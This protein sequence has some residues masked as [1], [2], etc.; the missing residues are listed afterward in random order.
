MNRK[1]RALSLGLAAAQ[2]AAFAPAYSQ[3]AF[4]EAA[5]P[6]AK[7]TTATVTGVTV[8]DYADDGTND[9]PVN[10][11][12]PYVKVASD[13]GGWNVSVNVGKLTN[14]P[15]DNGV[16]AGKKTFGLKVALNSAD[17]NAATKTTFDSFAKDDVSYVMC[18]SKETAM[19]A[20]YPIPDTGND[21][22]NVAGGDVVYDNDNKPVAMQVWLCGEDFGTEDETDVTVHL[23]K[24]KGGENGLTDCTTEKA[25]EITLHLKKATATEITGVALAQTSS[26]EAWAEN[27]KYV[28][29]DDSAAAGDKK[30]T[31]KA[32]FGQM[33]K[34][35][36]DKTHGGAANPIC[37][38]PLVVTFDAPIT[39]DA[40]GT[41]YGGYTLWEGDTGKIDWCSNSSEN[42]AIIWLDEDCVGDV[43]FTLGETNYTFTVEDVSKTVLTPAV[44][45]TIAFED[46]LDAA[47][48]GDAI[49]PKLLENG[50]L[51]FSDGTNTAELTYSDDPATTDFD[52]AI[53]TAPSDGTTANNCTATITLKNDAAE[54]YAFADA[55]GNPVDNTTVTF[56]VTYTLKAEVVVNVTNSVTEKNSTVTNGTLTLEKVTTDAEGV[57]TTTAFTTGSKLKE[58]DT[59]RLTYKVTGANKFDDTTSGAPKVTLG[60][61]EQTAKS[62]AGNI[63]VYEFTIGT[64]SPT[65]I[66]VAGNIVEDKTPYKITLPTA[67]DGYTVNATYN[68]GSSDVAIPAEGLTA[69]T[70]IK[71]TVTGEATHLLK[72]AKLEGD[73]SATTSTGGAAIS[74]T[75]TVAKPADGD[76]I[77][78]SNALTVVAAKKLTPEVSSTITPAQLTKTKTEC[79]GSIQTEDETVVK[80]AA[81]AALGTSISD[82]QPTDYKLTIGSITDN[83]AS[84]TADTVKVTLALTTEAQDKFVFTTSSPDANSFD[85]NVPLE[86]VAEYTVGTNAVANA[87]IAVT[88]PDGTALSGGVK[89]GTKV[90]ITV[91]GDTNYAI[92]TEPSVTGVTGVTFT[93]NETTKGLWEGSYTVTADDAAT[94]TTTITATVTATPVPVVT[95]AATSVT[96]TLANTTKLSEELDADDVTTIKNAV[97]S[98]LTFK[99]EATNAALTEGTDINENTDYT[100]GEPTFT[101]GNTTVTVKVSPVDSSNFALTETTINVTVTYVKAKLTAPTVKESNASAA[102]SI[103]KDADAATIQDL[104]VAQLDLP[105][106]FDES[107][108]DIAVANATVTTETTTPAD[109]TVTYTIKTANQNDYEFNTGAGVTAT[110]ATLQVKYI[111]TAAAKEITPVITV[112]ASGKVV[113]TEAPTAANVATEINA[114]VAITV[115]GGGDAPTTEHYT[116]ETTYDDNG[117]ATVTFALTDKGK[118]GYKIAGGATTT[119]TVSVYQ[120]LAL[121]TVSKVTCDL[122]ASANTDAENAIKQAVTDALTTAWGEDVM[123]HVTVDTPTGVNAS[124]A[125][126]DQTVAVPVTLSG[127]YVLDDNATANATQNVN[128]TY[129]VVEPLPSSAVTKTPATNGSFVVK[130]D[131]AEVTGNVQQGETV[132]VVPTAAEGYEIDKVTYAVGAA[133]A[134]EITAAADGSYTFEM[135]GEA[136]TVTVTFKA[137]ET[138]SVTEHNVTIGSMTNGRVTA[139][140]AKA[141]ENA[142][143]T[144]TVTPGAG[145]KLDTLTIAKASTGTVAPTKVNDTTYK[146]TMPAEAVTVSATFVKDTAAPTKPQSAPAAPTMRRRANTSI[147]LNAISANA[148]GAA[149]EYSKDGKTWQSSPTFTGLTRNTAYT[150]YARYAAVEGF[151]ASPASAGTEIKTTNTSSSGGSSGGGS[152]SGGSSWH[153]S[154]GG[155]STSSGSSPADSSSTT[156]PNITNDT[157]DDIDDVI[158]TKPTAANISKITDK[159][160]DVEKALKNISKP[161]VV[162]KQAATVLDAAIDAAKKASTTAAK[163]EAANNIQL[164]M[165]ALNTKAPK[166]RGDADNSG[167]VDSQDVLTSV[168]NFRK[169]RTNAAGQLYSA[170]IMG[171]TDKTSINTNDILAFIKAFRTR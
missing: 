156:T 164:I 143:V 19:G 158:D 13:S 89:A 55:S 17:L 132:T 125:A 10:K 44:S 48:D 99:N 57:E 35:Q 157:A 165:K 113:L 52:V 65:S 124:A 163:E 34:A 78:L 83:S 53:K 56:S 75:Y 40:N 18:Y 6:E 39:A 120:K 104:L 154:S 142:E 150:F 46:K 126:T 1:K 93:E 72:S 64:T 160:E 30:W 103:P 90:K 45:G 37:S 8:I 92:K 118:V 81:V 138:P 25:G 67:G 107:L 152:S 171:V 32:D 111:V 80:E 153:P 123:A 94:G 169:Y 130:V 9:G 133:A 119:A 28:T 29:L 145:Y 159:A 162:E 105:A 109:A 168:L 108:F 96:A 91:K 21:Y 121:P 144:L 161:S 2:L 116:L 127:I 82:L 102:A 27:L 24:L 166:V 5:K 100:I 77:D 139:N 41:L 136:V 3:V 70:E 51:T 112:P 31:L 88:K 36:Q 14:N 148:N 95:A 167:R 7:A 58:G 38:F 151:A 117:T 26:T 60:T 87:V 140:K 84:S 71:I 97:K 16:F 15:T 106:D 50:V 135:P 114:T 20:H 33:K 12:A 137:A 68:N 149:A 54:Q 22:T 131:N 11:N 110:V 61:E 101:K 23:V 42:T 49:I 129:D 98:A 85:V 47:P 76:T 59:L 73:P 79:N 147:T 155:S 170:V 141:A 62:A 69:G 122:D 63:Y 86:Y 43:T 128:V 115:A 134:T 66:T 74:L 4:A 146:F